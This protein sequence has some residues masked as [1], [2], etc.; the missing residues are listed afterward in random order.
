MMIF[1]KNTISKKCFDC[2][3]CFM[4]DLGHRIYPRLHGGENITRG[5]RD[6]GGIKKE[7]GFLLSRNCV[8]KR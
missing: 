3:T 2:H 4:H 8:K 7:R 5:E 1:A 6:K